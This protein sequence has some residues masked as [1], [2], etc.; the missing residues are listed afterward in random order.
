MMRHWK[1]SAPSAADT[2]LFTRHSTTNGMRKSLT[3]TCTSTH[4]NALTCDANNRAH[5]GFKYTCSG[6]WMFMC[7]TSADFILQT[8]LSLFLFLSPSHFLQQTK[9]QKLNRLPSH[10]HTRFLPC[11]LQCNGACKSQRQNQKS[12]RKL[13][14]L[15]EFSW[16]SGF[17]C[18][19]LLRSQNSEGTKFETDL[20]QQFSEAVSQNRPNL[21]FCFQPPAKN[22]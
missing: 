1:A 5:S 11:V 13:N 12:S 14:F 17:L 6:S 8:S 16:M 22:W 4:W 15:I 7:A 21:A 3:D 10:T 20:I 19:F 18:F 2:L 9:T